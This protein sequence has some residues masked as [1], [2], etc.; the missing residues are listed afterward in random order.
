MYSCAREEPGQRRIAEKAHTQLQWL[1]RWL[2][3][4]SS[5]EECFKPW[6]VLV[7]QVGA[8]DCR[9]PENYT[10]S[11]LKEAEQLTGVTVSIFYWLAKAFDYPGSFLETT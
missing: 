4:F 11:Q 7:W 9:C 2:P 10:I 5:K 3:I 6:F 1:G 8:A